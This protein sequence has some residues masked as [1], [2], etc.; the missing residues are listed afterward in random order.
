MKSLK[1]ILTKLIFLGLIFILTIYA[2]LFLYYS[3]AWK[4]NYSKQQV[5]TLIAK[6]N[7][8]PALTDSFYNLYDKTYKDRHERI[9][10]RYFKTFWPEFL[11]VEYPLHNNWQ[12]VIAN[13]QTYKGYR[14][15]RAPMTLAFRLN[16]DVSPE[17]CFDYIMTDRYSQYC[18]EF[19]I[20][21]TITNL[22][23]REQIIRFIVAN[24]LPQYYK[25]HPG[26]FEKEIDSMR[27][28]L[29]LD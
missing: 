29:A 17:K 3:F 2:G 15:K 12:Y 26:R 4:S 28:A 1:K 20:A 16:R 24:E 7:A 27:I 9:T 13:M 5:G 22:T 19:K 8:T 14:Y 25:F 18:K 10:T 23:D 21:D 11:M 6:I